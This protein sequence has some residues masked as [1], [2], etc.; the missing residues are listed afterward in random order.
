MTMSIS[1]WIQ[2]QH[3]LMGKFLGDLLTDIAETYQIPYQDLCKRY[4]ATAPNKTETLVPNIKARSERTC[5]GYLKTGEKCM[6]KCIPGTQLCKRHQY[7]TY[8]VTS[9]SESKET[10]DLVA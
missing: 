6:H 10:T 2:S 8:N 5:D 4:I 1:T 9:A 7:Q 3:S